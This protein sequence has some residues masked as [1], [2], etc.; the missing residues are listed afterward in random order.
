MTPAM[1][2]PLC[3]RP[4]CVALR[5]EVEALTNANTQEVIDLHT[6]LAERDEARAERDAMH[7]LALVRGRAEAAA[8]AERDAARE[9]RDYFLAILRD[10]KLLCEVPGCTK[11]WQRVM[12]W[13]NRGTPS[14]LCEDHMDSEWSR[15]AEE[16]Q[17]EN[18]HKRDLYFAP[19]CRHCDGDETDRCWACNGTGREQRDGD[20]E[21]SWAAGHCPHGCGPALPPSGGQP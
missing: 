16:E 13:A 1:A 18:L 12:C 7:E 15:R 17:R 10:H 5:R 14:S 11:K 8:E 6:A 21:H 9:A 20:C 2:S 3:P 4:E 19:S